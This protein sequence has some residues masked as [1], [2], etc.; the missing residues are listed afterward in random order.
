MDLPSPTTS[1]PVLHFPPVIYRRVRE[2]EIQNKFMY[3]QMLGIKRKSYNGFLR[4]YESL[5]IT[6]RKNVM[7][8]ERQRG[9]KKDE[10]RGERLCTLGRVSID[11]R[12]F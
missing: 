6:Q 1:P 7:R 9:E 5:K 12:E 8:E 11:L 4:V 3:H 2:D 10:R